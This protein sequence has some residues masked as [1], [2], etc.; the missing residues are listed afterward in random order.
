MTDSQKQLSL[1]DFE[2]EDKVDK[3][4][5]IALKLNKDLYEAQTEISNLASELQDSKSANWKLRDRLKNLGVEL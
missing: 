5:E 3:L 4:L 1:F 2:S